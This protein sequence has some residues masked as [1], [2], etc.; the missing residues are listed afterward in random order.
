[1]KYVLKI[2]FATMLIISLSISMIKEVHAEEIYREGDNFEGINVYDGL[3]VPYDVSSIVHGRAIIVFLWEECGDCIAEYDSY[4]ALMSLYGGQEIE[5]VFVWKGNIPSGV[6]ELGFGSAKHFYTNDM[7]SFTTWVPT[8]FILSADNTIEGTTT[9]IEVV[10]EYLSDKLNANEEE[11]KRWIDSYVIIFTLE[12]CQGC[13]YALDKIY[14]ASKANF[15]IVLVG[16]D[17]GEVT[18]D[19]HDLHNIYTHA[20]DLHYFPSIVTL[21]DNKIIVNYSVDDI[22]NMGKSNEEKEGDF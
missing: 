16:D 18:Y 7:R 21:N 5:F 17:T 9:D 1:M 19:Y 3:D 6:N 2:T 4:S 12:G 22:L 14:E 15:S 11:L 13:N 20:L 8:Y 10:E